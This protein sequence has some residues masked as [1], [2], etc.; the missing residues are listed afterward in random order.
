[1]IIA[2]LVD[3]VR[4]SVR[5]Q[6][7]FLAG[8]VT[9][10]FMAGAAR[11]DFS[12]PL[13]VGF[14][15]DTEAQINFGVI[16]YDTYPSDG[17]D[18][19]DARL[20][21]RS[22]L[23][24]GDMLVAQHGYGTTSYSD[25]RLEKG[26][27]YT[28]RAVAYASCQG[29]PESV[30]AQNTTS[31]TTGMV[32]GTVPRD[33]TVREKWTLHSKL[34]VPPGVTLTLK[35]G[36]V[37]EKE[38]GLQIYDN[39]VEIDGGKLHAGGAVLKDLSI[40]L[41][42]GG[43]LYVLTSTL[44]N[45]LIRPSDYSTEENAGIIEALSSSVLDGVTIRSN[46]SKILTSGP[47]RYNTG[48]AI[49]SIEVAGSPDLNLE[50]KDNTLPNCGLTV[51][52]N[53]ETP[54]PSPLNVKMNTLYSLT[55]I[56]DR[57]DDATLGPITI[58]SNVI[59]GEIFLRHG[60]G[61]V[62]QVSRNR[63][64][65]IKVGG[66]EVSPE[67]DTRVYPPKTSEEEF[68]KV[69]SGNNLA[70]RSGSSGLLFQAISVGLSSYYPADEVLVK[71]NVITCSGPDTMGL[72]V[73]YGSMANWL[74]NNTFN[75]CNEG[76]FLYGFES[77]IKENLVKGNILEYRQA[78]NYEYGIG[79][80]YNATDNVIE[81]NTVRGYERGFWLQ[82]PGDQSPYRAVENNTFRGNTIEGNGYSFQFHFGTKNNIFYNN[83]FKPTYGHVFVLYGQTVDPN[84]FN[85]PKTEGTNIIGGPY[86]GGNFW[87]YYSGVDA[88]NPK[89]GI[90]DTPYTIYGTTRDEL[91]LVYHLVVNRSGDEDD[92]DPTDGTC[93]IS[94]TQAGD[95]CTLRA[96]LTHANAT[97]GRN[98]IGF[99]ISGQGTPVISV[100]RPLPN[101]SE[102]VTLDGTTQSAGQ[103][104]LDGTNGGT[105]TIGLSLDIPGVVIKG[106]TIQNF[107]GTGLTSKG[108]LQLDNVQLL[109]NG[110]GGIRITTG[111][112]T[113][114]RSLKVIGN[115]GGHG[116]QIVG[117]GNAEL[118]DAT[119]TGNLMGGIHLGDG[120][121]TIQG[122]GNAVTGNGTSG[123]YQGISALAGSVE[124]WGG[125]DISDNTGKGIWAGGDVQIH[126]WARVNRNKAGG[127]LTEHGGIFATGDMAFLEIVGNGSNNP[128]AGYGIHAKADK[129]R[130]NVGNVRIN[131]NA[132]GIY[133]GAQD[134]IITGSNN[135]IRNNTISGIY[136][137]FGGFG[138]V[139]TWGGI[140]ISGNGGYGIF[141]G[142]AIHIHDWARINQN[143]Q[144][145]ILSENVGIFA[146]G[147]VTSLEVIGNGADNP[148]AGY[149]IH[150]K[151]EG[152]VYLDN[153]NVSDNFKGGIVASSHR[154]KIGGSSNLVTNNGGNGIWAA[155]GTIAFSG[156]FQV[157]ENDSYG[158]WASGLIT[159]SGSGQV[160][161]NGKSGIR[162][163]SDSIDAAEATSLKVVENGLSGLEAGNQASVI[164]LANTAVL[165]N[166]G[167]GIRTDGDLSVYS[168]SVCGN[169]GGDVDAAGEVTVAASVIF[170][171]EDIDGVSDS[172]EAGAPHN[173]DGNNDGIPDSRQVHVASLTVSGKYTTLVTGETRQLAWISGV[174]EDSRGNAI[175][176]V[177]FSTGS[178]QGTVQPEL[179]LFSLA[180]S[181]GITVTLLLPQDSSPN[182]FW[183]YGRTPDNRTP[184]WFEF[185]YDGETGAEFQ[186]NTV[187]LHFIDGLRGDLDLTENGSI[188][189]SGAPGNVTGTSVLVASHSSHDFDSV[190]LG[191][192]STPLTVTLSNTG[193]GN[194]LIGVLATESPFSVQNDRC[195]GQTVPPGTSCTFEAVFSSND[196]GFC[197][198]SLTIPSNAGTIPMAIPL[199]G[200]AGHFT[201][202]LSSGWNFV[203]TP[204]QPLDGSITAVFSNILDQIR[205][206]YAYD[207]VGKTWS[208]Y[209][210]ASEEPSLTTIEPGMGYWVYMDSPGSVQVVGTLIVPVAILREGWN[211]V[212][213]GGMPKDV[214]QSLNLLSDKW[215][216]V[217]NW[218]D[219]QWR[220]RKGP[221][222]RLTTSFP[223]LAGFARGKAF[224]IRIKSGVSM[225]E[226]QQ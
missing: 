78:G 139:E 127:I 99:N 126:D 7:T 20:C 13:N 151:G 70:V 66:P 214:V 103:V 181:A 203:S 192:I 163:D 162:S 10:L 212:G 165:S 141:S 95:Q 19:D 120:N 56:N 44:R 116:I 28:Y 187:V 88:S 172:V 153:I 68:K 94:T 90:G 222:L 196:P 79:L 96:A 138:S 74:L 11:A 64:G 106:M 4:Q 67:S 112:L 100:T 133:A 60:V 47:I 118:R 177:D 93:D 170:C 76:I 169:R 62:F 71:E 58:S 37:L 152:Y 32:G 146:S 24:R 50:I 46:G 101:V 132:G 198:G 206:V 166:T 45:T 149:G 140:D 109:S 207:N 119:V 61:Q 113:N 175:Q 142:A 31:V 30:V 209:K 92:A 121:L 114:T 188:S 225:I 42:G 81:G 134:I 104:V 63:A 85:G 123:I 36:A 108:D 200:T 167:V 210:P 211:L 84:I 184:H 136:T 158:I 77:R 80:I 195:S 179:G 102:E 221:D 145:G 197:T 26:R 3:R 223:N 201:L 205:I 189:F 194:A 129:G 6:L 150:A 48:S 173:G 18:E 82:G 53:S 122:A 193:S 97:P 105:G 87:K 22:E 107:N 180:S 72:Q 55:V 215:V 73:G 91:P 15:G 174:K 171:D 216:L 49:C 115:G 160:N 117:K 83:L 164:I 202:D 154:V 147:D 110:G 23:Y 38:E 144:G 159:I 220:L 178:Y 143:R 25:R 57:T 186:G 183:T 130:I 27:T 89:D 185:L 21:T 17:F 217:W 65:A 33:M 40:G 137:G 190:P 131:N 156:A 125:I 41:G 191:A 39:L 59:T 219:N 52:W 208:V 218:E 168:G 148:Q 54:L 86:L 14:T 213:Y 155:D 75:D 226:W 204:V 2:R 98:L 34:Y 29:Y 5:P 161:G 1:M 199:A 182:T 12:A 128:Q 111:N 124:I 16:F 176:G 157:S 69:I 35:E 51:V 43:R 224:W 8:L 9:I 135:E